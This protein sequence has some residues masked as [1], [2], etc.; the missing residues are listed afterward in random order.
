MGVN[1]GKRKNKQGPVPSLEESLHKKQKR[2]PNVEKRPS[3]KVKAPVVERE[4]VEKPIDEIEG[5]QADGIFGATKSSLFEDDD[6]GEDVD[7]FVVFKNGNDGY[8]N[9]SAFL[10]LATMMIRSQTKRTT[11]LVKRECSV[12]H[13]MKKN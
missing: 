3:K 4:E 5:V 6:E 9:C 1:A 13:Q 8:R 11:N 12:T 2:E 10:I 7:E